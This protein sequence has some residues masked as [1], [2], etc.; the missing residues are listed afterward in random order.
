MRD[1]VWVLLIASAVLVA[2][3]ITKWMVVE[4]IPFQARIEII[5]N[6]LAFNHVRNRGAAFG[7]FADAP[8]ELVRVGLIVVSLLAARKNNLTNS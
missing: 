8:S 2:D 1:R 4:R 6:F 3:Q 5:D 7:L